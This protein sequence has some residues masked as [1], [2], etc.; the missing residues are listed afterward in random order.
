MFVNSNYA[1][2]AE[3]IR[4]I[5]DDDYPP[6]S[7]LENGKLKG[8]Y[9]DL[10]KRAS[11]QLSPDY[12]I[13]LV[14]LPWKRALK[15]IEEGSEFAIL[16]PYRH[17]EARP[18]ISQYSV[19][20]GI[21]QVVVLCHKNIKLN[22]YFSEKTQRPM[23]LRLGINS[24]YLLLNEK[25]TQAV[26]SARISLESNKS[27]LLNIEKLL[28]RRIDCY[29][30][31]RSSIMKALQMSEFTLSEG[32][33]DSFIIKEVISSQSAHLGFSKEYLAQNPQSR[34][35]I[36]KLNNAITTSLDQN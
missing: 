13:Q 10:M 24:G 4:I 2:S 9:I 31:D 29:I 12:E 17:E 5:T 1:V 32:N 28:R 25:Y 33:Q 23:P 34:H 36:I 16:P 30:N 26:K 6:Y 11:E 27:T 18:F 14:P 8:I 19:V 7:Y 35:F 22:E 21:E 3:K 15:L 20:I